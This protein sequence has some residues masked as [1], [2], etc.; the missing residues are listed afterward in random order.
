MAVIGSC[1]KPFLSTKKQLY[2]GS[3]LLG[4]LTTVKFLVVMFVLFAFWRCAPRSS[5]VFFMVLPLRGTVGISWWSNVS[6]ELAFSVSWTL[7]LSPWASFWLCGVSSTSRS[8]KELIFGAFVEILGWSLNGL[9][10]G[11][12]FPPSLASEDA[13]S[14]GGPI[15]SFYDS[16]VSWAKYFGGLSVQDGHWQ[17]PWDTILE[18]VFFRSVDQWRFGI[19]LLIVFLCFG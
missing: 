2:W 10:I 13:C 7:V 8:C 1:F 14:T 16:C 17:S 4:P 12:P 9:I 6:G 5:L 19:M 15:C 18:R 3:F 11:G